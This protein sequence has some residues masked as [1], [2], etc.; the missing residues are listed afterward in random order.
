MQ[1]FLEKVWRRSFRIATAAIWLG[2]VTVQGVKSLRSFTT[3]RYRTVA[4][5]ALTSLLLTTSLLAQRNMGTISGEVLDP[6]GAVVPGATVNLTEERT[7]FSRQTRTDAAGLYVFPAVPAGHYQLEVE[8]SGFKKYLQKGLVLQVNQ[9]LTVPVKPELGQ[10]TQEITVT[11][12]APQVDV[13]SGTVKEVVDSAR[14]SALPLNGRNVLQLQQLVNGAIF[15][16][17]SPGDMAGTPTYSFNG[18]VGWSNNY[19]LDGGENT[20][21]FWNTPIPFPNPDAIQEFSILTSS[22]GAEYGRNRGAIV[23]AITKSGTNEWH[24]S[25]YEFVRNNVFDSKSFFAQ[26][27]KNMVTGEEMPGTAVSPFKRNQFGGTIGGP[28]KK[29][30]TFFFVGWE[31]MRQRGAPGSVVNR[32]PSAAM[33]NGDF[34]EVSTPIIN[35]STGE[36]FPNNLMSNLSEPAVNFLNKY[37]PLPNLPGL[38][39]AGPLK[40]MNDTNQLVTRIDHEF[41]SK[42]RFSARY[43]WNTNSQDA[44]SGFADWSEEI[45][46]RRQSLTL[47]YTHM[48][49]PSLLNAF[50]VTYNRIA[51]LDDPFP[52]FDWNALGA[53]VPLT[54]ANQK[55]W[56]FLVI[57]GY[58]VATNGVP[59]DLR[60]NT[61]YY[62]NTTTWV[63]GRHT[64]KW[65]AQIS[66]YQTKQLFEYLSDGWMNFTGQFTNDAAADF[67][68]GRMAWMIQDSPGKNDLRETLWGFYGEDSIKLRPR[69]TLT[70]GLRYEPF[71]GLRELSGKV[72]GIRPGQQSKVFPTA[73][74]GLVFK[75]D[76]NVNPNYFKSDWNNFAPRLG[77]AWDVFGDQKTAVRGGYGIFYDSAAAARLNTFP[78][79]QPWLANVMVFDRPLAD[80]YLGNPPFPYYPPATPEEKADFNFLIPAGATSANQNMVTPYTQQFNLTIERQLPANLV[81][82]GAYVGSRSL[83]LFFSSQMNPAVYGPGATLGNLQERKLLPQFASIEDDQTTGYSWYNSFQLLVKRPMSRG[84]AVTTAYTLSKDIGLTAFQNQGLMQIRDP[85]NYSLDK[86][87]LYA[88][89]THVVSTSFI[90]DLP[91]FKQQAWPVRHLLGGWELSGILR[92][93][94]GFPFTVRSGAD[95]SLSGVNFDTADLV[96][97]QTPSYTSGSKAQRIQKWFN[98]SAFQLNAVGTVGNVGINTMRGPGYWNLDFGLFKNF[99]WHERFEVQYRAEFFNIFNHANLNNP[100]SSVISSTFGRILGTS[101]PR[102]IEM[103]LK[104]RF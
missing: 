86:G 11:A 7:G 43:L 101:D 19:T 69:L 90:W 25:V 100:D 20:D 28:I 104:F 42:D 87:V 97:G 79:N 26:N 50:T 48:F 41:S 77:F 15:V 1:T 9:N 29:N 22:Y 95:N 65:G 21:S 81:V 73:P 33:R 61:F 47:S 52:H 57:N 53:K 31:S 24:G 78:L 54:V 6:S 17:P 37:A 96:P 16:A 18:G 89:A 88:D 27:Q 94:S 91:A 68:L 67:L 74:L 75:G 70:L 49:S 32:V 103:A 10:M 64:L 4:L 93:Q 51:E 39:Y 35:P 8:M 99:R 30:K 82:S 71:F 62:D 60:R 2:A 84:F 38:L 13:V 83:K 76:P 72:A 34:S 59:W 36:P 85:F 63:K 45:H 66:R 98:T 44:G 58:F 46:Y 80:P 5:A 40:S 102:V 56:M 23:N 92:V 55:G 3:L 12:T 14:M